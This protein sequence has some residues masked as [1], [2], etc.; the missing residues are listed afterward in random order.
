MAWA[1]S[2]FWWPILGQ[3]SPSSNAI[4][5]S[6]VDTSK[7][8]ICDEWRRRPPKGGT[9]HALA[10]NRSTVSRSSSTW[11]SRSAVVEDPT[12]ES[13][14]CGLIAQ[15]YFAGYLPQ[16]QVVTVQ[17]MREK[18]SGK[19]DDIGSFYLRGS[20]RKLPVKRNYLDCVNKSHTR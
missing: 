1:S 3:T 13:D 18:K 2:E 6:K 14:G 17:F 8:E 19:A 5:W 7:K 15:F 4:M 9:R 20:K 12:G 10:A 11:F 16:P